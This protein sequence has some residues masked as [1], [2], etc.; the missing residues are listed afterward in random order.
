MYFSLSTEHGRII[1]LIYPATSTPAAKK[2]RIEKKAVVVAD[3]MAGVGPFAVP[4]AMNGATVHANG[5][6]GTII[7]PLL[8]LYQI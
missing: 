2:T 8:N 1:D 3:I 4:L 7:I 5:S 6:Y